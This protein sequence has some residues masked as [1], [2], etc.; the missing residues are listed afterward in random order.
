MFA[1]AV[2]T[3]ID[4]CMWSS[5]YEMRACLSSIRGLTHVVILVR[6]D[7]NIRVDGAAR[8]MLRPTLRSSEMRRVDTE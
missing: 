2:E 4:S 6:N 5:W 3:I 7:V 1:F 8:T